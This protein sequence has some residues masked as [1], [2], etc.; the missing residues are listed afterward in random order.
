MRRFVIVAA[1]LA[2]TSCGVSA[3]PARNPEP[4][5]SAPPRVHQVSVGQAVTLTGT[6]S[7][8]A[9]LRMA[10]KVKTVIAS[11]RGRGAYEQPRRGERFAAVRFVLKNV[12]AT[13]YHDSPTFGAKLVDTDGRGYDPTV[14]TVTAGPGFGRV[15]SLPHDAVRAGYIVFAIPRAAHIARVEYALNAGDAPERAAWLLTA[16]TRP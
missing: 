4:T 15:V 5:T 10:V 13:V 12:G 11:A 8:A 16:R 6:S 7:G 2:L 1:C 3:E 9:G 14:A